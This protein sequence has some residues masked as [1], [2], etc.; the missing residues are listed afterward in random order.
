MDDGSLV[1]EDD[2][3][4]AVGA[5]GIIDCARRDKLLNAARRPTKPTAK[6]VYALFSSGE[7]SAYD[8]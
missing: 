4:D 2:G 6:S 1:G 5:S 3:D 7:R 8:K